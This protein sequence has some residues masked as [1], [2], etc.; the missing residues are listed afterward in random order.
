MAT[1]NVLRVLVTTRSHPRRVCPA[2]VE[3]VPTATVPVVRA[4]Q[5]VQV[6]P[7][8]V[9][10]ARQPVQV[11]PARVVRAPQPALVVRVPREPVETVLLRA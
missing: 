8:R 9:V 10:R 1:E 11:A 3:A 6:A 5:P 2:R 7:V 4:R